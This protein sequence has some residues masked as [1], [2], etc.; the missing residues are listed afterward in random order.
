M[1]NFTVFATA[2]TALRANTTALSVVSN[3]IANINTP[4][5]SRQVVSL[6]SNLPQTFGGEQIGRGVNVVDITRNYSNFA[7]LRVRTAVQTQGYQDAIYKNVRQVESVF[8]ELDGGGIG[9][10]MQSFFDGFDEIAN[11]PQSI[12]ARQNVLNQ[13]QTMVNTFHSLSSHLVEDRQLIDG[14]LRDIVTK[15]N[16]LAS[17][18]HDLTIKINSSQGEANSLKDERIQKVKQLSQYIDVTSVETSD[19]DFQV[20][21]A[22]GI[23]LTS[24]KQLS[25]LSTQ[26]N[27]DN[28]GLS[29]VLLS[30]GSGTGTL[31][32]S[33][34]NGG[35]LQG[36]LEVRD[37]IIPDYQTRFNHLAY[38][39]ATEVNQLHSAGYDLDGDTGND[40]FTDLSVAASG[41]DLATDLR[42][43]DG[44]T[45][46]I[47]SGDTITIGGSVGATPL[48]TTITV[49]STTTLA[50][51]ASS[52]QTALRA[53][54]DGT[55]TVTVR[56]DGS[57]RV[58]SGAAAITS[59]AL[60]ISGN[61]TFNTA[62]TFATPITA[63]GGTGDSADVSV[64]GEDAAANI[65]VSSDVRSAPR[66][67][68]AASTS[69]SVPG[70]NGNALSLAQLKGN[71][72]TFDSGQDTFQKYYGNLL[73]QIG[74]DAA[75]YQ[76]QSDFASSIV[77]QA[78][79]E[80]ERISGVAI[81]EE[82]L[83]LVR[84]QAAFQAATRLVGV[85]A[86]MLQ[87]LIQ[88]F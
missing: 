50:G 49:S 33:R 20:Y 6:A 25:V 28:A 70:G 16:S 76:S 80:R 36:L 2:I 63:G 30:T 29:D 27:D 83:D 72:I 75:S 81:E 42:T 37:E 87:S 9:S 18:I 73:A 19:E 21:V 85:A 53:A 47:D 57:L 88:I 71:D 17:E 39:I 66:N 86:D 56:T 52:L 8:N 82:Q 15:V 44:T 24:G 51:I 67:I 10:Q 41:T 59:L 5:Y 40:F 7:D 45:L 32:T 35:E 74:S 61:T 26:V 58:T 60:S 23:M 22:Q 64:E 69:G 48:A 12:N 68:A 14:D 43:T 65:T 77:R 13:A 55:E 11:D 4:G 78:E 46:G 1:G 3:N 54:G 62:Y 79:V 84:Y 31:I 38:K 34:I